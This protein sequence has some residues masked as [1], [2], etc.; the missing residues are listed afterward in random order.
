MS[1]AHLCLFNDKCIWTYFSHFELIFPS[2]HFF[3]FSDFLNN[4]SFNF[5][6]MFIYCER[7]IYRA[8][9]GGA[10]RRRQRIPNKLCVVSAEP[11]MGLK[12][13]DGEIMT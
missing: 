12:F 1:L 13:T 6:K 10:E 2:K 4:G 7:E 5:L 3:H 9:G 11:N 8:S